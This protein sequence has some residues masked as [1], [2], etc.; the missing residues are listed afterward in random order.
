MPK[1]AERILSNFLITTGP[2]V[3]S[4]WRLSWPAMITVALHNI[5]SLVDMFY[6]GRLGPEALGAV[7]VCGTLLGLVFT[8]A[9]GISIGSVALVARFVGDN[10]LRAAEEVAYQTII[11]AL[12]CYVAMAFLGYVF[13]PPL[14]RLLGARGEVLRLGTS[15]LRVLSLGSLT[16]FLGFSLN[17]V[18]RGAGDV[19]TPMKIMGLAIILNIILDPLLI[20]GLWGFP[21]LEVAG[22]ALA[23]VIARGI[24]AVLL[25][26]VFFSR[27]HLF[28][29]KFGSL[30]LNLDLMKRM[31]KIGIFGSL[32]MLIRSFAAL[33]LMCIVSP[34]GTAA[35]AAYGIVMRLTMF[36]IMPGIGI[37]NATAT[38][39]GQNLGADNPRRAARAGWLASGLYL[40]F[41]GVLGGVFIIFAAQTM[42]IFTSDPEVVKLG[43][44]YLRLFSASFLFLAFSIVLGRALN[45]AGDTLS[46]MIT[47]AISFLALRIPLAWYLAHT[48]GVV[49]IW[50][51]IALSNLVHGSIISYWFKR[52]KWKEKKV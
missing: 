39:V 19:Q 25:F 4:I 35:I 17:S 33:V 51:A 52:G 1:D 29:L 2:L 34:F 32:Q 7:A 50:S 27:H 37:G 42:S 11:L 45:G 18:L 31:A 6:V 10:D 3:P 16:I 26:R 9:L 47:T 46:P 30:R 13:T 15:Y 23:T 41:L 40:A 38:M 22:S 5:F 28:N 14:L 21:R 44:S 48:R 36:S 49:G 24:G 20:F 12:L 43:A 8:L